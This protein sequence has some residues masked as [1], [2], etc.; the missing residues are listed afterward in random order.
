MATHPSRREGDR[1]ERRHHY[2]TSNEQVPDRQP[3]G[4]GADAGQ[5]QT[6]RHGGES[7]A[8]RVGRSTRRRHFQLIGGRPEPSA[9]RLTRP[10]PPTDPQ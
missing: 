4:R 6:G 1:M 9:S 2:L 7:S 5:R 10:P 8:E 3:G